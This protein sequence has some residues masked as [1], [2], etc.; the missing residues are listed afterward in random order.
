M[1]CSQSFTLFRLKKTAVPVE[2]SQ[3]SFRVFVC[4]CPFV[5]SSIPGDYIVTC[6]TRLSCILNCSK[7]EVSSV[8]AIMFPKVIDIC[9]DLLCSLKYVN[10]NQHFIL[11]TYSK[12][13]LW[14]MVLRKE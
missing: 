12:A 4:A 8:M 1:D 6:F 7:M 2:I 3:Y 5:I 14:K 11:R 13:K 9:P 10:M